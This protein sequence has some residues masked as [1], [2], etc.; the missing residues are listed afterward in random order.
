VERGSV[1]II[2]GGTVGINA[3]EIA[4]GMGAR[5][6]VLERDKTRLQYLV[7][8][9]GSGIDTLFSTPDSLAK[10]IQ[11]ADL[12][13]GAVLIPGAS[14]PKI[15]RRENLLTMKHAS[16]IVDVSVDQRGCCETSRPTHHDNPV[17]QEEGIIH[18]CVANMPGSVP[19]TATWGLSGATLPYAAKIA[20]MG[21]PAAF[22]DP[23]IAHGLN[24]Y[25]GAITYRALA[26]SLEMPYTDI[27]FS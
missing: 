27:T 9:F 23:A 13:I 26:M 6:S 4:T 2:G 18:Y 14:T 19:I 17:Y 11:N 12:V 8:R 1:L 16:V 21:I 5:V 10:C 7:A 15:V 3:A 22:E 24:V 20:S 25:K